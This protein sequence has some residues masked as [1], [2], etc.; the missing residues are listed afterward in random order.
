MEI[1]PIRS[2]ADY[3]A[4]LKEIEKLIE[5]QPGTPEGD[6]ME[7]LVTLVEAYEAKYF[8]LPEPD[9]P[10]GVLEYYIESRGLNRSDLVAYLGS[11][12][13]VSEVLNRKRGLSLEMI[14]RLHHGLG[15]PSDLL[16]GKTVH[17]STSTHLAP[18]KSDRPATRASSHYVR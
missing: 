18:A 13:R 6:R 7:V 3:E 14:R 1:K 15:I 8:P 10:V 12:E 4:A 5:S 16:M 11:K 9:D 2:E 17:N